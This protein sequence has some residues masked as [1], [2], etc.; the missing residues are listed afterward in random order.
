[1][2]ETHGRTRNGFAKVIVILV[3]ALWGGVALDAQS[4]GPRKVEGRLLVR[5]KPH[6]AEGRLKT[7][8][9]AQGAQELGV[10]NPIDVRI[11]SVPPARSEAVLDALRHNPN[12]E[13]AEQDYLHEPAT[14]PN[15]TYY[16]LEWHLP[17]IGAPAAW[18]T[19]V[20]SNSVIIAILDSGVDGTHPDLISQ[21][22][23]GWNLY[24]GNAN[25][26]DV[27]G[28]GTG[29]AGNAAAAG[30][31]GVGVVSPAWGCKI[32][33]IRIADTN[34][35]ASTS[36]IADG[37]TYAADHGARVANVSFRVTG[38]PTLSAAAQYLQ[39]RGG[40]VT[41]SAGNDGAF[42]PSPDDPYLITVSATDS[43]DAIA[44]FSNTGNS[45]DV[46]APGVNIVTTIRG[47][48]YGYATGTSAS[49]PLVAGVAA[50][51]ISVNP[52]LTGSQMRDLIKQSADDLGAPGWD[53]GYGA[54][55]LRADKA[56]VAAMQATGGTNGPTDTTAPTTT[57]SSPGAG[58][59][60]SDVVTIS[61]LATDDVGITMV[62]CYMDGVLACTNSTAPASFSW[63]TSGYTNGTYTL[64]ARA[65]DAAG[66][67]GS[68]AL[69]TVTVQNVTPD[70]IA[71]TIQITSPTNGTA[72]VGK[73]MSV[74]VMAG[75]N[76]GV[77]RV[78]LLVDGKVYASST[79][80]SPV[81]TWL[82]SK[83]ARGSHFLQA[84][85]FDAAGNST[86]STAVTV[87]K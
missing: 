33:P 69:T 67:M 27:T 10:I 84:D 79:S 45:I 68:S 51:M 60:V 9:D 59:V 62:E 37:V 30:N 75:D 74:R 32:M 76:V 19:T 40:V 2:N 42:D 26:S 53:T 73:S 83:L 21:L 46:S 6:L 11:L 29:V 52:S 1:M 43:N 82:T 55:R 80:A 16:S 36:M 86:R 47:G 81:F 65:Y 38:S 58:S 20:G 7:L 35:Y 8:F 23:P 77:T 64:Q 66:N 13:F 41:V 34:G 50:L 24:D 44:T 4:A 3:A 14:V 5:P 18:D 31:N 17:K 12:I 85:A 54:G 57:I 78:R 71:P 25:T 28:H 72:I 49:A 15:D 63:D 48:G 87:Y 56:V 70:V 22:V 39:S 61:I